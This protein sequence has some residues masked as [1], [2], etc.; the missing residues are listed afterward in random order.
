MKASGRPSAVDNTDADFSVSV[1]IPLFNKE[2]AVACTIESVLRQQRQ[3]DEIIVID[4]GSTD[5]SADIAR[6][7]LNR[8]G[9]HPAWRMVTQKNSGVSVARNRGAE[10][11]SSRYI[12]FLDADD[13][14]APEYL[15]EL[16]KLAAAFPSATV[17]STR[18]SR[19]EGREAI[20]RP[21]AL[22]A[23]FFGIIDRPIEAYR[24]GRGILNSS[25]VA[26]RR[27]AW[28]RCGGFPAGTQCGE[29]IYVWL[30]LGLAELFAHSGAPLSI[31][32]AEH[33]A[34]PSRKG[35]VLYYLSYFLDAAEGRRWLNN[36]DLRKFLSSHLLSQIAYRREMGDTEVLSELR[37]LSRQLPFVPRALSSLASIAPLWTLRAG[38][39]VARRVLR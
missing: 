23:S 4:D 35:E 25:S 3:P 7:L 22:P 5:A 12:A 20:P 17:L 18:S 36:R 14:W 27:D 33:S 21:T 26:V 16:E 11:A 38:K 2:R 1:V 8:T 10:E 28:D 34:E 39:S 24:K 13:E 15:A 6:T 32:H 30:K 31:N 37:R 19:T 9:K 29:D